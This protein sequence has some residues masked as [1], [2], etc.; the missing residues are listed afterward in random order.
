[1]GPLKCRECL[2]IV[3]LKE[4]ARKMKI[5]EDGIDTLSTLWRG[6]DWRGWSSSCTT[7]R[8]YQKSGLTKIKPCKVNKRI[9]QILPSHNN[10]KIIK[11]LALQ[12]YLTI[13]QGWSRHCLNY[14]HADRHDGD[15]RRHIGISNGTSLPRLWDTFVIGKGG[16]P[17]LKGRYQ[18]ECSGSRCWE[19]LPTYPY[20]NELDNTTI[21]YLNRLSKCHLKLIYLIVAKDYWIRRIIIHSTS[22]LGNP[23]SQQ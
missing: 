5:D 8:S 4:K 13:S 19:V 23:S 12:S 6:V 9:I 10:D 16:S 14:Y 21:L 18:E 2:P 7:Q 22:K 15:T 3:I 1:M 20:I 11:Y 17:Y